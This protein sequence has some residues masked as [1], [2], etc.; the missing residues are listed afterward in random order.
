[1]V[2]AS[3]PLGTSDEQLKEE[4]TCFYL[5]VQIVFSILYSEKMNH[6]RKDFCKLLCPPP[7]LTQ[8]RDGLRFVD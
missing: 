6:S 8:G 5:T 7:G 3:L 4:K 1:M 2:V